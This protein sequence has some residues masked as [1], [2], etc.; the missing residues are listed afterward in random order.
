MGAPLFTTVNPVCVSATDTT[1][2]VQ[3]AVDPNGG[4][5]P[6]DVVVNYG[7]IPFGPYLFTTPTQSFVAPGVMVATLTGLAPGTTVW[8]EFYAVNDDGIDTAGG[9]SC[10]TTDSR[11]RIDLVDCATVGLD[12]ILVTAVIDSGVT[13]AAVFV[14][15]AVMAGGPYT[16]TVAQGFVPG[17]PGVFSQPVTGLA[18]STVY[19]CRVRAV[20]GAGT[21][22]SAEF[23]CR[24]Q[25]GAT[26]PGAG[27]A[28]FCGWEF[29]GCC[30][31]VDLTG[32][33]P[34][35]TEVDIARAE[36]IAGEILWSL[37][38]RQYG[39]C[40]HTI[41]PCRARC[42]NSFWDRWENWWDYE[43][44]FSGGYEWA[45]PFRLCQC[46][47]DEC[48]CVPVCV[49]ELPRDTT[50]ILNITIDG[51]VLPPA[52]YRLD[53][54]GKLYRLTAPP[55]PGEPAPCWPECNDFNLAPGAVGT[56]TVTYRRGKAIPAAG[57][58][59]GSVL[60]CE[61][62]KA[63]LNRPCQLPARVQTI[64]RNGVS[65]TFID[66]NDFLDKQLTGLYIVD[67]W[68]RSINPSKL[69]R[70]PG[71]YRADDPNRNRRRRF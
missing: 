56:W 8:F 21:V 64:T 60:F 69:A 11:P 10:V 48:S 50:E 47:I 42:E 4:G 28:G 66:P 20:N 71:V 31:G 36:A 2:D 58:A 44:G 55:A 26:P 27:P 51:V 35:I 62:L 63:C 54:G 30:P 5:I 13:P 23:Q 37:S 19:Y 59:A 46:P 38:G 7:T 65:M 34:T 3:I 49:M 6:T 18:A 15:Y 40:V 61:V 33:D 53:R 70:R 68:L 29:D 43:R 52:E 12:E 39:E 45:N 57:K 25:Q 9:L 24:T 14:D 41:R 1:V 32:A 22:V 17:P 67:L 16:S